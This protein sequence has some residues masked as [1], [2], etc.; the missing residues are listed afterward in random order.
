MFEGVFFQ[1]PKLGFILFF[2][3]ACEALCPLRSTPIYFT[4]PHLFSQA[5]VRRP[6]WIWLSKWTM[7]AFLIV[8]VMSPVR[9]QKIVEERGY[10]IVMVLD[11][12]SIDTKLLAEV[13][14]FILNHPKDRIALWI[15]EEKEVTVPLTY[16][17]EALA[18][19]LSQL[20]MPSV[21]SKKISGDIGRFL[22]TSSPER[23]WIVLLSDEPER[24][25]SL[26]P[27][28]DVVSVIAPGNQTYWAHELERKT[29]PYQIR[30]ASHYF[31]YYYIYPL[32][33]GFLAMLVYLYGR[34]QK[35]LK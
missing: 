17:H 8:A 10:D 16:E 7:I 32:F 14:A 35:G 3:L 22:T 19:I 25:A 30:S 34:N 11:P 26:L 6:F 31:E 27:Q 5:G 29:L 15:P 24:F 9:E 23:K 1:F 12:V 28:E 13:R 33:I 21:F 2:F 4:R 18:S 20:P